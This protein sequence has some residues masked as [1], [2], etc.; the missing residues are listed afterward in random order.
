MLKTLPIDEILNLIDQHG[1]DKLSSS[2]PNRDRRIL[3]NLV[4]L[5]KLPEFFTESQGK[6]LLKILKENLESLS[7][8]GVELIPSLKVPT[9]SRS[10]KIVKTVKKI[11]ITKN[12]I[13]VSLIKIECP[14]NK[15]TK[16]AI[17]DAAKNIEGPNA[18]YENGCYQFLLTERN[19][20]NVINS[21]KKYNF[22]K[23]EEIQ[24]FYDKIS[25]FNKNTV[26]EQ[27]SLLENKNEKLSRLLRYD[28]VDVDTC[29]PLLL[30][31]RKIKF[32][33]NFDLKDTKFSETSLEYKIATR[34]NHKIF[35]N[36]ENFSLLEISKAIRNLRRLPVMLIFDEY[37][38]KKCIDNLKLLKSCLD[39]MEVDLNVGVYFRFD[40]NSEGA[41][42][43]KLVTEYGYNKQLDDHNRVAVVSNGKL[44]KFFLK[45]T[46]YPKSV[47]SFSNQFRNNKTSVYCN[48]C[49]LVL[50]YNDSMPVIGTVDEIV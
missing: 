41:E 8:V 50:Y 22:E 21:L 34:K 24:G 25:K 42:F 30:E 27:F 44:P 3:K 36:S 18:I 47:I 11:Y 28:V 15:D 10:F 17:A 1:V 29:D 12:E 48:E 7:F 35:L 5:A 33:Y 23:S 14:F 46:W 43:N 40:S 13:G 45:S 38:P 31:D 19:L 4:R 9:W 16:K 49:D 26:L 37:Q 32:Q 6:L 39:Q 2:V 20:F